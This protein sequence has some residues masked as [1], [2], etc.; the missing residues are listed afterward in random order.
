[1]HI[2]PNV[3]GRIG[4]LLTMLLVVTVESQTVRAF[5]PALDLSL[6]GAVSAHTLTL[7]L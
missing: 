5:L 1:M 7:L 4:H 3:E 2:A 6:D